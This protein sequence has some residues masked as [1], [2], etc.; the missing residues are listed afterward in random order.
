MRSKES[1]LALA[2]PSLLNC[3]GKGVGNLMAVFFLCL[4]NFSAPRVISAEVSESEAKA[5]FIF[6]IVQFIDWEREGASGAF[7]SE[8]LVIQ[9]LR[10]RYARS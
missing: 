10:R 8:S 9:I 4:V 3:H 5:E 7:S 2:S 1:T 6:R